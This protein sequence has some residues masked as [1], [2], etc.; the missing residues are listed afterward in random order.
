MPA[1]RGRPRS[2]RVVAD[3]S[4]GLG[5]LAAEVEDHDVVEIA[6]TMA[7]W[8]STSRIVRSNW[9]R[10]DRIVSPS[11]STSLWVRP[12]AGLVQHQQ[13]GLGGQRP[14]EL[15]ALERAERQ[16]G[17][18]PV[19]QAARS[20]RSSRSR[21]RRRSLR[22]WPRRCAS[23]GRSRRDRCAC[24]PVMTFSSTVSAGNRATF[25]NVRARPSRTILWARGQ[26]VLAV[27]GDRAGCWAGTAG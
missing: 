6:M 4:G 1:P 14:G 2:P 13:L 3:G 10:I 21:H 11:S 26:Q 9:S 22:S 27:E 8:C 25:W 12:L 19:G 16:A 5:D 18:R 17:D 23:S 20:S 7:M 15:D 24:A